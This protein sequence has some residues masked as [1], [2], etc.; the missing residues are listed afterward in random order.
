[1]PD[2]AGASQWREVTAAEKATLEAK[3]AAW[4][5]PPESFIR[6]WEVAAGTFGRYNRETGYFE[7][8]GILDITYKEAVRIM[9][10]SAQRFLPNITMQYLFGASAGS[11]SYY[12]YRFCR[13]YLPIVGA[14]GYSFGNLTNMFRGNNVVEALNFYGGYGN[15][16]SKSANLTDAFYG[17]TSLRKILCRIEVP[18]LST[19]TFYNCIALEDLNLAI[20]MSDNSVNLQWSPKLTLQSVSRIV[21]NA[22]WS[23]NDTAHAK[24]FTATVHAD[25]F[26]KLTGD[27]SNAAAAA[28]TEEELASWGAVLEAAAAKNITFTTP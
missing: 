9:E 10:R 1:M 28:L 8:N 5:A 20:I 3:A 2:E 24:T 4:E 7:L 15:Q 14:L 13:T 11:E 19:N 27:T 25:V 23:L 18:V 26:A 22:V 16:L 12:K 17:C 6:L 21:T